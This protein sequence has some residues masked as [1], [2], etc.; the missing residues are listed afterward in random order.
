[1]L[2]KQFNEVVPYK[3]RLS[4][5]HHHQYPSGPGWLFYPK[6]FWG[7]RNGVK[8]ICKLPTSRR[9]ETGWQICYKKIQKWKATAQ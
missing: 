9:N 5:R 3:K 7:Y 4:G 6:G 8:F 1:M 2:Q